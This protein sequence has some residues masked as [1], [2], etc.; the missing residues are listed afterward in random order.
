MVYAKKLLQFRCLRYFF[1]NIFLGNIHQNNLHWKHKQH[2]KHN[3]Q[4]SYTLAGFDYHYLLKFQSRFA[5]P[6]F[7][8]KNRDSPGLRRYQ[9]A[10]NHQQLQLLPWRLYEYR[11]SLHN[12]QLLAPIMNT[13]IIELSILH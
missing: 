1:D 8:V 4:R 13:K 10:A 6:A 12:F 3:H 9:K 7:V 2:H 11:Y 5:L